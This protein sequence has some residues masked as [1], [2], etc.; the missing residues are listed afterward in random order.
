MRV[1]NGLFTPR[2][3]FF[4]FYFIIFR[5]PFFP[6]WLTAQLLT[7]MVFAG[8]KKKPNPDRKTTKYSDIDDK[9]RLSL[10]ISVELAESRF[11][12]PQ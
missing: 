12:L 10:L 2:K 3:P 1:K 5:R 9:G 6:L 4:R 7:G 8:K 11:I